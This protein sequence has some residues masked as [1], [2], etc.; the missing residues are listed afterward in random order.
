MLGRLAPQD[1]TRNARPLEKHKKS[2]APEVSSFGSSA[3]FHGKIPPAAPSPRRIR[4][5]S[6]NDT[7]VL[8]LSF[9]IS[10]TNGLSISKKEL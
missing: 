5:Y 8:N 6:K 4:H 9:M 7:V 1:P 10:E 2:R 3:I